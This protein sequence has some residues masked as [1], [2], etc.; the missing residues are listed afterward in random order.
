MSGSSL[1]IAFLMEDSTVPINRVHPLPSPAGS[2]SSGSS[3][4]DE[5]KEA[6][7]STASSHSLWPGHTHPW[8]RPIRVPPTGCRKKAPK[9]F[10]QMSSAGTIERPRLDFNKMQYSKRF[11]MVSALCSLSLLHTPHHPLL[12]TCFTT[13]PP[14]TPHHPLLHT[15]LTPS[16][17]HRSTGLWFSDITTLVF[18]PHRSG[19]AQPTWQ[20]AYVLCLPPSFPPS[21]PPFLLPSGQL[22]N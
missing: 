5:V 17:A 7:E 6:F 2:S 20:E 19:S 10:A 9:Y 16:M 22:W 11:V 21:L 1:L 8:P 18:T 12:H 4:D 13:P 3:S 15:C 14:H